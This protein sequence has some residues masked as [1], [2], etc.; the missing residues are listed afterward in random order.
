[1]PDRLEEDAILRAV[2]WRRMAWVT[3]RQHR[4]ALRGVAA[5]LAALAVSLWIVGRQLHHAYAAAIA[6]HPASSLACGELIGRFNGMDKVLANGYVLQPLPA[7]IGAFVGAPVLAREMEAGTFRYVWTQGFGRWRW[8]VAKLV[9]LGV[10]VAAAAGAFS[11]LVSWYYEPYLATSNQTLSIT[12]A[13][14]LTPGLFDLRGVGFAAWTLAAFAIGG[15]GGVLVRRVVPAIVAT[16]A[17]YAGLA[18]AAG[19]YLRHHYLAS[20]VTS[21]PN[22]WVSAG[23]A[24]VISQQWTTKG[25]QPV[26]LSVL[27]QVLQA[28]P[29]LAGKG[30]IPKASS[31]VQYLTQHGYTLLTRYQPASRFWRFQLIEAGWLVGL[32]LLLISATV[33][34]VRRWAT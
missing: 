1:M 3:W 6:C 21:N 7:L 13:S 16:L 14:P 5:L 34:L 30:G 24:W 2:P 25:G 9:P 23:S 33:W 29:Q 28:A 8:A 22:S 19:L 18:G 17:T 4:L 27:S 15:L 26:S 10:V 32:A 20:L 12:E 31:S 11:M